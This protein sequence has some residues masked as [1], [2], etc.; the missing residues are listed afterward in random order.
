MLL[1]LFTVA[2]PD[3]LPEQMLIAASDAGIQGI[4]WRY[5]GVP[6]DASQEEPSFWRRNLASIDPENADEEI[7]KAAALTEQYG[8]KSIA[9]VPYLTSG[10]LP[11]TEQ[12]FQ[13]AHKLSASMMRVGVPGYHRSANYNE[14]YKEAIAYLSAVQEMSRQYGVKALVE[15][16]HGT[17]AP[18]AGL[19]HRLVSSFDPQHIGVLYD[20]GNMVHEGY[21][22]YRMGLELLGPYLAHV[23]VK[24]ASWVPLAQQDSELETYYQAKWSPLLNGVVRWSTVLEDLA[25]V[26]YKGYLGIEDFSQSYSSAE[27]LKN[28][29]QSMHSLNNQLHIGGAA[30]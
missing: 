20:P 12:A 19:A 6:K 23:H 2:T 28:F 17:I 9:L 24:N 13:S 21:E 1:S 15:T 16:H 4:E 14:L 11:A 10:D 25:A 30:G 8:L 7:A 22:N 3:L 5:K 26:G 18:S 27:M 29:T